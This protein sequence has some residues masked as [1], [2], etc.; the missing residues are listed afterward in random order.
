[1]TNNYNH[2]NGLKLESLFFIHSTCLSY[3]DR[4]FC[5]D[6]L[7]LG[8]S[9]SRV[10]LVEM[11]SL[12]AP[13]SM[14]TASYMAIPTLKQVKKYHSPVCPEIEGNLLLVSKQVFSQDSAVCGFQI[15][16]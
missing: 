2:F 10:P 7:L 13:I 1:M 11:T 8:L 12:I 3:S 9:S 4:G 5:T 6:C 14:A 15:N 16:T